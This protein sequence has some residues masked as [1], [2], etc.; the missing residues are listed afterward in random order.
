MKLEYKIQSRFTEP[1]RRVNVYR[2]SKKG[3]AVTGGTW[4]TA[5]ATQWQ[6][7]LHVSEI[8]T[9]LYR[10]RPEDAQA[11]LGEDQYASQWSPGKLP[12]GLCFRDGRP[13]L[14]IESAGGSYTAKRLAAFASDMERRQ[15]PFEV[16]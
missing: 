3:A 11:F 5:K 16:F 12:D 15:I 9:W 7:D 13:Y 10:E 8:L 1:A 4:G 6:H 14:A 2:A